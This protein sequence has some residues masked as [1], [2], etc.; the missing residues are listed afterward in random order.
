F[1]GRVAAHFTREPVVSTARVRAVEQSW[2]AIHPHAFVLGGER[3]TASVTQNA[4]VATVTSGVTNLVAMKTADSAF[5]GFPR[6]RYTTLPETEDR[7]FV[8]S[9]TAEWV[10]R[11]GTSD[12][13]ARERIRTALLQSFAEHKSRS[14]QHTLAA[15]GD[16][17][18]AAAPTVDA[19]TLTL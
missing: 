18:L 3:W 13:A 6:D 14:V 19:I 11:P 2:G 12:F 5:S 1:A 9:I 8:T 17:A 16:A 4:T 7:L 10:H 15:M